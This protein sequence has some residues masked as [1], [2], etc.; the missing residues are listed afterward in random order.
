MVFRRR[1]PTD[2]SLRPD[3][4]IVLRESHPSGITGMAR[5]SPSAVAGEPEA[6]F[7][8]PQ[9]ARYRSRERECGSRDEAAATVPATARTSPIYISQKLFRIFFTKRKKKKKKKRERK[10][11]RETLSTII[12]SLSRVPAWSTR[13][14]HGARRGARAR[15]RA[16]TRRLT[17][18]LHASRCRKGRNDRVGAYHVCTEGR[19][20]KAHTYTHANTHT[21]TESR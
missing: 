5:A 2:I 10:K 12:R 9:K 17:R 3:R 18:A 20:R 8:V 1:E 13:R 15:D 16:N 14:D 7:G 19:H 11:K 6:R 21:H 4:E